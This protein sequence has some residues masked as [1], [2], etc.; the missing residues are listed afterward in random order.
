MDD[1]NRACAVLTQSTDRSLPCRLRAH[2]G[3]L[4][5]QVAVHGGAGGHLGP[6]EVAGLRL[7]LLMGQVDVLL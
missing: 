2:L 4:P 7:H 1:R 3:V 6:T 5:P